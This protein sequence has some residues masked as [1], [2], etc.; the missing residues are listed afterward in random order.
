MFN[1]FLQSIAK[2]QPSHRL[3]LAYSGGLDSQVLLH[4]AH[5]LQTQL[6]PLSLAAVHVHHGLSPHADAWA[7]HCRATCLALDIPCKIIAVEIPRQTGDSL[8]AAA[9]EARYQAFRRVLGENEA[10]LTAQHADDQAET[11]LLQLLRGAGAPGLAAM[12]AQ[13]R[14]GAGW[15]LR[16]LLGFR[17]AELLAYAQQHALSWVED[18]SNQNL[19][20]DRNYLRHQILPRLESR[21]RGVTHSLCRAARH[22]AENAALLHELGAQDLAA[23]Q[24]GN[25]L[26]LSQLAQ[27]SAP[28]TN[29]LLRHWLTVCGLPTPPAHKLQQ[30]QT[31]VIAAGADRQP[32]V[33][34]S[35]A[36][37]RRYRGLLYAMPPLPAPPVTFNAEWHAQAAP[38]PL[39]LGTL[40]LAPDGDLHLPPQVQV[41]LRHGGETCRWH[42]H[43][44]SV[45]KL[46][47]SSDLPTWLRAFLP[48]IY[49]A[50]T[51]VAVPGVAVCDPFRVPLG[52]G[53]QLHWERQRSQPT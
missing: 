41:R 53:V 7:A 49:S 8:E 30:I 24:Q 13:T 51:L 17:R 40:Q 43:R 48:L 19:R 2:A 1:A 6:A 3:W 14:C 21:W 11:L 9:R 16:P 36:Q 39:P 25:A 37:V 29:N 46:L 22:Q 44:V 31:E 38:P 35:G 4:L 26:L 18:E 15:L 52:M 28:R 34:W 33:H 45:K 42:G 50:D 23:C 32:C 10:L 12:P 27:L 47:Q 5:C 20:F